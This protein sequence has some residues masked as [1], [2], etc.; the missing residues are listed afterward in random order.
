MVERLQALS[1]AGEY[2]ALLEEFLREVAGLPREQ[3]ALMRSLPA[4]DARR[5]AAGT[6]AREERANR[7]YVFDA[8]RFRGVCVPTLLLGGADSPAAFHAANA[9]LQEALAG[10]RLAVMPGQRH[11]AMDTG[12][13][14]F[15]AEVL[16]FLTTPLEV[17]NS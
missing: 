5:A 17:L 14:L 13:E 8:G 15:L 6:I 1:Y 2:D 11:V 3:I 9:A 4:W 12:T 10:A 16:S 7:D